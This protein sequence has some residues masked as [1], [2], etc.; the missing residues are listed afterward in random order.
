MARDLATI[1][2]AEFTRELASAYQSSADR[3]QR[4]IDAGV[5][6]PLDLKDARDAALWF[7]DQSP[8]VA[9]SLLRSLRRGAGM[10]GVL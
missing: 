10:D 9:P 7:R 2:P 4:Q 3:I 1:T 6:D 8:A 5:G